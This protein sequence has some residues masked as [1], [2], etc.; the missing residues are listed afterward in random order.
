MIF[1]TG[2]HHGQDVVLATLLATLWPTQGQSLHQ[3]AMGDTVLACFGRI[4]WIDHQGVQQARQRQS[5]NFDN[6]GNN[7]DRPQPAVRGLPPPP[8]LGGVNNDDRGNPRV[9]GGDPLLSD[10]Q[11]G[12]RRDSSGWPPAS[13]VAWGGAAGGGSPCRAAANAAPDNADNNGHIGNVR[14]DG[15]V[16][17]DGDN[18][19][20]DNDDDHEGKDEKGDDDDDDAVVS[21]EAAAAVALTTRMAATMA[22]TT[23][24]T[25]MMMAATTTTTTS[26][27]STMTTTTMGDGMTTMRWQRRQWNDDNL[28]SMGSRAL[29]HPSEATINL[30]Q[31]FGEELT[32]ERDDFGGRKDRKGSRWKRLGGDHFISTRSIPNQLSAHPSAEEAP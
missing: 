13:R 17:D 1:L 26:M 6:D 31:Q 30:C 5:D 16:K 2:R 11:R 7:R 8:T 12:C 18:D 19:D 25:W 9:P 3:H 21:G 29:C 14:A 10:A 20:L 27:T 24:V 22:T 23:K 4:P 28:M 15:V 32:R